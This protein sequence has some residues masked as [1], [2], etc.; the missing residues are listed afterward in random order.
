[1]IWKMNASQQPSLITGYIEVHPNHPKFR[2]SGYK[3]VMLS[4]IFYK[5]IN[6]NEE[7]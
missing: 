7:F 4:L 5:E 3:I 6:D 2:E 1:M